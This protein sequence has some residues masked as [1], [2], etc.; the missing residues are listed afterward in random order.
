MEVPGRVDQSESPAAPRCLELDPIA[1]HPRRVVCD[2][3]PLAEEPVHERRLADV[4]S[5]DDGD[6]RDADHGFPGHTRRAAASAASSVC[7][8]DRSVVS[9]T[10]APGAGWR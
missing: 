4:L 6:L 3:G 7:S 10:T 2:R 5:P 1:G 9:I 8:I